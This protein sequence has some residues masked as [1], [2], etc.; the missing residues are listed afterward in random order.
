MAQPAP[1]DTR[2]VTLTVPADFVLPAVLQDTEPQCVADALTLCAA[3]YS[4][5]VERAAAL[6][7]DGAASRRDDQLVAME[8]RNQQLQADLREQAKLTADMAAPLIDGAVAREAASNRELIDELRSTL[9]DLRG[10]LK[11]ETAAAAEVQSLQT[12][13]TAE[14]ARL[15]GSTR[16]K[17]QVGETHVAN[18][19]AIL[20]PDSVVEP[21]GDDKPHSGDGLWVR[22]FGSTNLSMRCMFEVK[23]VT[24][25]R[26][27][28]TR[29]FLASFDNLCDGG[30]VNCAMFVSLQ[31]AVFPAQNGR[32]RFSAFFNIDWRKGAPILFVSNLQNNPDML[33]VAVATM[34]HLWQFCERLGAVG[35]DS[36]EADAEMQQR[37]HLVNN[38]VN[39]QYGNYRAELDRC[40]EMD[41]HVQALLRD[42]NRRRA[43]CS[44]QVDNIA[45]KV[46]DALGD[47][48]HLAEPETS[49]RS[50]KKRGATA[51]PSDHLTEA[52]RSVV[53]KC[54]DYE[55]AGKKLRSSQINEGCVDGVGKYDVDTLFGNFST[56]RKTLAAMPHD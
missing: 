42:V 33:G 19:L 40:D 26:A 2:D 37:A 14:L 30:S 43:L 38:F 29:E 41:K 53:R 24:R 45:H 8:R 49:Q 52:Q 50:N 6:A 48:V 25:I 46:A 23:N 16:A 4:T 56:L 22:H 44:K 35:C 21:W 1:C 11:S 20:C 47:M 10:R 54:M 17:G 27:E 15:G 28:E 13:V 51:I 31:S 12:S 5:A 39:E 18:Q 32:S 36:T 3:V 55:A 9:A 34:Q 7:P